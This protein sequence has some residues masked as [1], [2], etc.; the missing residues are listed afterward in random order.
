MQTTIDVVAV[1]P[2]TNLSLAYDFLAYVPNVLT[3]GVLSYVS[4]ILI[5]NFKSFLYKFIKEEGE[6]TDVIAG[7]IISCRLGFL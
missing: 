3:Y 1:I 6:D 5:F 4:D 2:K 7:V